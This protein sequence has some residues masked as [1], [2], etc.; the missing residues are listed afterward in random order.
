[1]LGFKRFENAAVTM[2]GIELA[3]RSR[4]ESSILQYWEWAKVE[5]KRHG[6]K[7]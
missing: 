2:S 5:S 7:C 4:R 3:E 6:R 1:M